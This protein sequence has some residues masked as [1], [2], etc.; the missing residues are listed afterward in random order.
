MKSTKSR[1]WYWIVGIVL[2]LATA[3]LAIKPG[4]VGSGLN[5]QNAVAAPVLAAGALPL[6]VLVIGGT[7]G[8][9]L[10]VA[11]LAV[12]RGHT[13]TVMARHAPASPLTGARFV[14]GDILDASAVANAV[15]D[16]DAVVT[17]VSAAPSRKPSTLFSAGMLNVLA[18]MKQLNVG[19]LI[20]VTGIGAGDSRGHGGFGYDQV[21]MP[22][23]MRGLY[24][25]KTVEESQIRASGIEWTIVRPGFLN[26]QM[27]AG[28]FRVVSTMDGVTSGSVSRA[29]VAAYIVAAM[30]GRLDSRKAVLLTN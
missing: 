26:N 15:R 19:R 9:G 16:Q 7:S 18:A 21:F 1:K 20:A 2:L 10:E 11:R 13:V 14:L 3:G 29:D 27:A 8:I 23:M 4:T 28:K 30:E 25:D 5:E 17:S 22:L 24:D 12:S 6:R